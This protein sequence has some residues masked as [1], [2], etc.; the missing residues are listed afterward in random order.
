[1]LAATIGN[2]IEWYDFAVYGYLA[3]TL[4]PLFFPNENQTAQTLSAFAVFAVGYLMRH[5]TIN[6][7]AAKTT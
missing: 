3:T 2:V 7:G 5:S 4:G 1:M 6:M